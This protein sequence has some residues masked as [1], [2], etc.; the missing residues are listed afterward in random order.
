MVAVK[1]TKTL[2]LILVLVILLL[3]ST[4]SFLAGLGYRETLFPTDPLPP[5][6]DE[7]PGGEDRETMALFF[8]VLDIILNKYVDEVDLKEL[9]KGAIRGM[10]EVLGDPQTNF[11]TQESMQD[12]LSRTLGSYSG[13][14]I[15]IDSQD[16]YITVIAPIKGT[17]AER[18][19]LKPGDRI[20]QVDG[21]DI[22]GLSTSEAASLMRG[23]KGES[24]TLVVE[25][26]GDRAWEVTI[27]RD[28][29]ELESVF[30][31]MLPGQIGYIYISNFNNSTG[32]EFQEALKDLEAAGMRGLVLD[33]RDN[34]GGLLAEAIK[35]G[36]AIVPEGPITHVVDG[37]GSILKTH[38]SRQKK[39]EYPIVVLVN[40]F[41]ASAS[42]IVAGALQDS[43]GALLVGQRTFGKATVQNLEDLSDKS[44]LRYTVAK[45]LTP[46]QRN[47]HGE[48]LYPDYEVERGALTDT[49]LE[50]ALSLIREALAAKGR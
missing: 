20:L 37:S 9:E 47:I 29:I 12:M 3:S 45:Y 21:R 14:G 48:G 36:Q 31:E 13:I 18:A 15:V 30:P 42:E 4:A 50:K 10:L 23:P 7:E 22:K 35:V 41:S 8:E 43:H 11:F 26:P 39:K 25:R 38:Y 16:S 2:T 49:Q 5:P 40:Q 6:R 46:N 33:L 28:D 1:P 27:I 34:P 44:G 17:P 24:V 19:G 32:R